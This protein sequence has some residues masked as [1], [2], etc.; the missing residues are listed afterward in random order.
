[1]PLAAG[2]LTRRIAIERFMVE[3]DRNNNDVPTWIEIASVRAAYTPVSDG[4]TFRAGER[5]GS[6]LARFV[7]RHS[8]AVASVGPSDRLRF[9][10]RVFEIL[11]AKEY[12][13]HRVGIE[14]TA[15]ARADG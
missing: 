6:G 9:E 8:S 2:S 13:G 7:I 1:M 5:A 12:E 4:E 15:V 10:G 3:K 11:G 14:L